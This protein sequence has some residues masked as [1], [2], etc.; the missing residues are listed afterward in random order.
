MGART[1]AA[2]ALAFAVAVAPAAA[3][4][5]PEE[6][7]AA[8]RSAPVYVAPARSG[9]LDIGAVGRL[10][11]QIAQKDAGRIHIA[12]IP[13]SWATD[14]GG[15]RAFANGVD[16]ELQGHGALLISAD[17]DAFVVTSHVHSTEAATAVQRAFDKGGGGLEGQLRRS[18]DGLT[19]VDPGRTADVDAPTSNSDSNLPP[20]STIS[21]PD[22]NKIVSD[23]GNTI[24]FVVI[25]IILAVL[26]PF[27]FFFL[28]ATVRARRTHV[29]DK[30]AFSDDLQAV[31]D[32]RDKLGDDIVDLDT[33]TS[34]PNVPPA[35][36][37]AYEKALDA[38]DSSELKLKEVDS[39]RR[40][41]AVKKLIADGRA[42]AAQARSQTGG[43]G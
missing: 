34:M 2:V 1:A 9:L 4:T 19:D 33:A 42:A 8:L 35:A 22:P 41:E 37:A 10:Q 7:A 16:A 20:S 6:V 29:E 11:V 32:E 30:E 31:S 25:A 36:R 13:A 26:S 24:K 27:I 12:V 21:F 28:R 23:V 3:S 39:R 18:I 17:D 15:V 5:R 43:G 40:L 38:Y 14:E